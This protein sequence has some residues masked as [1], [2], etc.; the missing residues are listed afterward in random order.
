MWYGQVMPL[1][2]GA[3]MTEQVGDLGAAALPHILKHRGVVRRGGL[4]YAQHLVMQI[5][6][7]G[8]LTTGF[9]Q[10]AQF[11]AERG[12]FGWVLAQAA[13]AAVVQHG[14]WVDCAVQGQLAPQPAE[15]IQAPSVLLARMQ[16]AC[17][18]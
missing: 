13:I 12:D 3:G 7:G 15:D 1:G 16:R 8:G 18:A 4:D 9:K 10:F 17:G 6:G 14:Q 11:G 2:R 5:R